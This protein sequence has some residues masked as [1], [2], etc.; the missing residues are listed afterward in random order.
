MDP[1]VPPSPSGSRAHTCTAWPEVQGNPDIAGTGV[2]IGFV[3]SA[4]FTLILVILY[5]I[6]D[7]E[8]NH[9]NP[10]D[11]RFLN[12]VGSK[13]RGAKLTAAMEASVLM[14]SDTQLITGMSI[15]LCG[16]TQLADGL[17]S[18]HWQV[19][20]GLAWFSSLTHLATLTSLRTHFCDRLA[21]ALYR[22]IYMGVLLILLIVSFGTTGYVPQFTN[23]G[24]K[25]SWPAKCLFSPSSMSEVGRPEFNIPLVVLSIA[26]LII[27]Y[28]TRVVRVFNATANLAKRSLKDIPRNYLRRRYTDMTRHA[29]LEQRRVLR[30]IRNAMAFT[31]A[32]V[33]ILSKAFYDIGES[34]L[35]E[36]IWLAAALAWGTLR[37]GGLRLEANRNGIHGEN[38][39]GF[40]QILPLLLS[41]LPL[42]G[43]FSTVYEARR[44]G[45]QT[46]LPTP[47]VSVPDMEDN[48]RD[49]KFLQ[50]AT[51][52]T[53]NLSDHPHNSDNTEILDV[54]D[55]GWYSKLVIL[56]FGSALVLM[57]SCLLKFPAA[58]FYPNGFR[59][60]DDLKYPSGIGRVA[61]QYFCLLSLCGLVAFCFTSVCLINH[62][63][64]L[65][66]RLP[67]AN[68]RRHL[69]MLV[70]RPIVQE[71]LWYISIGFLVAGLFLF[72]W[73]I[74]DGP[75]WLSDYSHF[76][77]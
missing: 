58:P 45:P 13:S 36:I 29:G 62:Q 55:C 65:S 31:L 26:F 63:K 46:D 68:E 59:S 30:A 4:A 17:S 10:V 69:G 57:A 35:W 22:A 71:I 12:T 73:F 54:S 61:L 5:Y 64:A 16:Y 24:V 49:K 60:Q 8:R 48:T 37:I 20:I 25:P 42:W 66:S 19:V 75:Y 77:S 32:V 21:M 9:K 50:E 33:Y 28:L 44:W 70:R 76:Y 7:P 53:I 6:S 14:S 15:L 47:I 34:M 72:D 3:L 43:I 51:V 56:L 23:E 27:S 40:G 18:Y 1:V 67:I 11:R 52:A 41:F 2:L 39:W 38:I 74:F